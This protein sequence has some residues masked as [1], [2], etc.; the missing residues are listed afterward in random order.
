[1]NDV[2]GFPFEVV[3]SEW[4]V[5]E[6]GGGGGAADDVDGEYVGEEFAGSYEVLPPPRIPPPNDCS[7]RTNG[8]I[9]ARV[10][11]VTIG[12]MGGVFVFV[13]PPGFVGPELGGE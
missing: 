5:P 12:V 8:G 3:V 10:P 13:L 7:I 9:G 4:K 2:Y 11:A 6:D 1:M